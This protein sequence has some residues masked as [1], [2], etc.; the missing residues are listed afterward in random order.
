[1][2]SESNKKKTFWTHHREKTPK[3]FKKKNSIKGRSVTKIW[4]RDERK[5]IKSPRW[6]QTAKQHGGND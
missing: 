2:F 5:I 1:M 4:G 3:K 6:L